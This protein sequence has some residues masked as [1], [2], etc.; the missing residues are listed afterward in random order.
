VSIGAF[1]CN[2][3]T[4][5]SHLKDCRVLGEVSYRIE[6]SVREHMAL[7]SFC[8]FSPRIFR[9]LSLILWSFIACRAIDD[10][11]SLP[12]PFPSFFRE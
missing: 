9:I 3:A 4:R 1:C 10:R 7:I 2:S 6:R 8:I 11:F 12:T 5:V